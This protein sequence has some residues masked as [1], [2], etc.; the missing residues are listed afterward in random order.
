MIK[1][2]LGESMTI[3]H[4]DEVLREAL[5]YVSPEKKDENPDPK[6]KAKGKGAEAPSDV[7]AGLD[8]SVYKEIASEILK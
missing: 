2:E 7:F 3:F 4:M 5:F 1:D 8:T 6:A